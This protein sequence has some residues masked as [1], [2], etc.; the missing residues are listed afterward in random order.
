MTDTRPRRGAPTPPRCSS[1]SGAATSPAAPC[2]PAWRARGRCW[3]KSRR[4]WPPIPAARR[5]ARWSAG[6]AAGWR[7]CWRCWR[8]AAGCGS[9][10]TDV[11]LNVAGGLRV[12]EPAADLAVAA[13]LASAAADQPTDPGMRLFRRGRAVRRGAPGRAGRGAAEGGAEA[14]ASTQ[15]LPAAPRGPRQPPRWPRPRACGCRRSATSPTW[16]AQFARTKARHRPL[17]WLGADA[18][19][20]AIYRPTLTMARAMTWVDIVVAGRDG[21]LRPA[22]VHA[23]LGPR[24]A[25]HRRLDRRGRRRGLG[26]RPGAAP[27]FQRMDRRPRRRRPGRLRARSSWWR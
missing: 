5:A 25:G 23:R 12:T 20:V 10:A 7:C 2:S 18:V 1:P 21:H 3:W 26:F 17:T 9:N 8:R 24:G 6:T 16:C 19:A 22:G 27:R 11:Y 14:R 15:R 4:C 13:A